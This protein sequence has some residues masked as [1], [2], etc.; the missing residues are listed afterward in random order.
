MRTISSNVNVDG[1]I[2]CL[3]LLVRCLVTTAMTYPSCHS[4]PHLVFYNSTEICLLVALHGPLH[5][6]M[7]A[8]RSYCSELKS[9][10]I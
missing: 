9:K 10:Q 1:E 5:A 2:I 4:S 6:R 7:L 3:Q 8:S